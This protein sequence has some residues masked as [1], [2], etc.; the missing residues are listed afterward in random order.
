MV[1]DDKYTEFTAVPETF[2]TPD[3]FQLKYSLDAGLS[4]FIL[5]ATKDS[6]KEITKQKLEHRLLNNKTAAF[7]ETFV[8]V[9]LAGLLT[10]EIYCRIQMYILTHLP[11]PSS[12]ISALNG[13]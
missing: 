4:R 12:H 10:D 13:H 8:I 11:L 6:N 1:N 2:A 3:G 7:I 5:A 9:L